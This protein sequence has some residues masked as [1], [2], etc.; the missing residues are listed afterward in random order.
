MYP[1][2]FEKFKLEILPNELYDVFSDCFAHDQDS[3]GND[4][5]NHK[6]IASAA[7]CQELCNSNVDCNYFTYGKTKLSGNC[8]LK[9]VKATTLTSNTGLISGPKT[10]PSKLVDK[11]IIPIN[12]RF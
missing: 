5:K 11:T 10:C 2:A 7:A 9:S 12:V 6:D 4:I 1:W 8:W 3:Y